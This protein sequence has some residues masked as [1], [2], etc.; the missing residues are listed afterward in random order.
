MLTSNLVLFQAK[1]NH[2]SQSFHYMCLL[3][4]LCL[5]DILLMSAMLRKYVEVMMISNQCSDHEH[6][7]SKLLPQMVGTIL[8][9]KLLANFSCLQTYEWKC[10]MCILS[11][12][13]KTFHYYISD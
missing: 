8:H 5:L 2:S 3:S 6:S 9:Q 4:R 7:R 10:T 11:Y 1:S 13:L 12:I